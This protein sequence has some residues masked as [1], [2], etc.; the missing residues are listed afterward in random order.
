MSYDECVQSWKEQ[1]R[2]LRYCSRRNRQEIYIGKAM[3]TGSKNC[4]DERR[5]TCAGEQNQQSEGKEQNDDRH[6]PPFFVCFNERPEIA[7]ETSAGLRGRCF[8]ESV[9]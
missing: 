4:I 8:F 7:E 6:Q 5:E 3:V 2:S 1:Q 9:A